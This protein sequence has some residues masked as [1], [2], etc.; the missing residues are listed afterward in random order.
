MK[1]HFIPLGVTIAC[2]VFVVLT[3]ALF[4]SIAMGAYWSKIYGGT[5]YEE[6]RDVQQTND[7]GFIVVVWTESFG[8]RGRDVLVLKLDSDG[9]LQWQR[10]YGGAQ[11]DWAYSIEQTSDGGYIIAGASSS[12]SA[13]YSLDMWILKLKNNGDID[14][15]KVYHQSVDY[16]HEGAY[17][18]RQTSDGGYIAVGWASKDIIVLKLTSDGSIDWQKVIGKKPS[19]SY[20]N[21]PHDDVAYWVEQTSDGGYIIAGKTTEFGHGN[22]WWDKSWI[23]KLN[24]NGDI[25]WNKELLDANTPP[26]GINTN[27]W[28]FSI[29]QTSDG[30]Y[31]YVASLKG[32]HNTLVIKLDSDGGTE[33]A[34]IYQGAN[35]DYG[36]DIDQTPDGGYI[37]VGKSNSFNGTIADELWLLKLS[38][39]GDIE[40]QKQYGDGV[41]SCEGF[42][43]KTISDGYI[44]AGMSGGGDFWVLKADSN[45][46]IPDCPLYSTTNATSV[47]SAVSV[48]Q[49][50]T[51]QW[52]HFVNSED[53]N[54]N[55][56]MPDVQVVEQCFYQP[57]QYSLTVSVDPEGSGTVTGSG[58]T[59]P[60]ECSAS[61]DQG[62]EVTLTA[63]PANGYRFDSWTGDCS[64]CDE[65]VCSITINSDKTCIANFEPE[66]APQWKD[67]TEF[68]N[69]SHS[70]RSLYERIHHCFFILVSIENSGDALSGP[71]RMVITNP[72]IPVKEGVGVGLDPDGYT[73]DGNPYF[74]LVH[75]G[76]NLEAG[77]TLQGLRVNFQLQRR[78]LTY[79]IRIEEL[80]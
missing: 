38:P 39:N 61:Y 33:W 69:I 71:I 63:S 21:D 20:S 77:E 37:I 14:W 23:I 1:K 28:K 62:T 10:T 17:C 67:I 78:R 73:E 66:A 49:R 53:S 36:Y 79:G 57:V 72:N 45:G 59:C 70:T 46:N 47:A 12:F 30:G 34:K 52:A 25:Q 18:V 60:E 74:L 22:L 35:V 76:E 29:K 64:G 5:H 8:A 27:G 9:N 44:V 68:I 51:K 56:M 80:Q 32:G 50:D 31:I 48:V 19:G 54:A 15:Q 13:H 7:G 24:S 26:Y 3:L 2:S 42:A 11:N 55:T 6:A 16:A 65:Q 75:D 41:H 40:W 58:I 4:S 43:V